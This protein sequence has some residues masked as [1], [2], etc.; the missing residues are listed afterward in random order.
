MTTV[1]HWFY[2]CEAF[3]SIAMVLSAYLLAVSGL[4]TRWLNDIVQ[5]SVPL[6]V[7]NCW[8]MIGPT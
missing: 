7:T 5:C 4:M 3:E 6:T 2:I 8:L 1:T